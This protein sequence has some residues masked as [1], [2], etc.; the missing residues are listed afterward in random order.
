MQPLKEV[1][2]NYCEMTPA[3]YGKKVG[4]SASAVKKRCEQGQLRA[5]RTEGG[6]WK[7]IVPKEDTYPKE[8]VEAIIKE[9]TELRARLEAAR[10]ALG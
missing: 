5:N 3:Q 7:I 1:T 10:R 9:N 2:I 4:L 8:E 6:H